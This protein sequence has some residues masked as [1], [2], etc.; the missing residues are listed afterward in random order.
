MRT[1]LRTGIL[2]GV[3]GFVALFALQ[4]LIAL[5]VAPAL[6]LVGMLAGLSAAKWLEWSWFGRQF[7]AGAFTGFYACTFAGAGA[8][9]SLLTAG[10]QDVQALA[11]RSHVAGFSLAPLVQRLAFLS[12]T[13]V[14]VLLLLLSGFVGIL[15]AGLVAQFFAWSKNSR[16]VQV[17]T[18]AHAAAEPLTRRDSFVPAPSSTPAGGSLWPT[19]RSQP[20]V[21]AAPSTPG[22]GWASPGARGLQQG[23]WQAEAHPSAAGAP[24]SKV[25]TPPPRH[26]APSPPP[27]GDQQTDRRL[28]EAERDALAAWARETEEPK[29]ARKR[30][31]K[32]SAY[33]NGPPPKRSRKKQDT[34][35]WLC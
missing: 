24:A 21:A 6:I 16:T 19:P 30:Q 11:A 4:Q 14:D 35:D 31:P 15:A 28:S 13:G 8:L 3:I 10:S 33:L 17:V 2:L 32:T 25:A 22:M 27:D 5:A 26:N 20:G 34:R 29:P 7:R 9:L 1:I 12:S 23:A 18:Q